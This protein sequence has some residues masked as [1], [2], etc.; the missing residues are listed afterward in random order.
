ME[1]NAWALQMAQ[2]VGESFEK[3]HVAE[4]IRDTNMPPVFVS[5]HCSRAPDAGTGIALDA[6]LSKRRSPGADGPRYANFEFAPSQ[7]LVLAIV[8][9]RVVVCATLDATT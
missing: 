7:L 1:E 4:K 3:C 9:G 2:E 8:L 5:K 6:E